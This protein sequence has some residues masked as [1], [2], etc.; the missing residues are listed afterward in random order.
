LFSALLRALQS[1]DANSAANAADALS[2]V[3]DVDPGL[4]RRAALA[5]GVLRALA[6][7]MRRGPG[8]NAA[9]NAVRAVDTMVL[10]DDG[11]RPDLATHLA[12]E[13]GLLPALAAFAQRC[14][15]LAATA[16]ARVLAVIASAGGVDLASLVGGTEGV[17][18]ALVRALRGDDGASRV[19]LAALDALGTIAAAS[20]QDLGRRVL[21]AGAADGAVEAAA[22]AEGSLPPPQAAVV[23][24]PLA[25]T[26]VG[27]CAADLLLTLATLDAARVTA[28][29]AGLLTLSDSAASAFVRG[30][31]AA[32]PLSLGPVAI[33]V[34]ARQAEAAAPVRSSEAALEALAAASAV[35]ADAARPRL[36]A[37]CGM[38][39]EAAGA[40]RLRMCASCSG[41]GPAG[42]VLYC[43][44]S[45]QRAHWPAHKAYCK[46]AAAAAAAV[47]ADAAAADAK[48]AAPS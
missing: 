28:A 30:V 31:L 14:S 6:A 39:R 13:D 38:Q 37:A 48:E 18:P 10:G 1:S 42:R 7:M 21:D 40:G 24:D 26:E 36:C 12:A 23:D 27:S 5:P 2:D 8:D 29:L 45:C 46:K 44:V 20:P 16:P 25:T 11:V 4:A 9:Q 43:G 22:L 19:G 3:C 35:E 33:E 17:V 41:K 32:P 34:L 15:G 47:V